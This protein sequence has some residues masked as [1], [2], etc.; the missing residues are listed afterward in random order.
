MHPEQ[1]RTLIVKYGI[2]IMG[3]YS[4][5]DLPLLIYNPGMEWKWKPG[6]ENETNRLSWVDE[7]ICTNH[8]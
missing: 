7:M 8:L 5:S 4:D 6:F 1:S 3:D 2:G